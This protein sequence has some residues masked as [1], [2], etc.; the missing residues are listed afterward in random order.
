MLLELGSL[1]SNGPSKHHSISFYSYM[2]NLFCNKSN[3]SAKLEY[4]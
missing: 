4:I 1:K 3:T 2:K